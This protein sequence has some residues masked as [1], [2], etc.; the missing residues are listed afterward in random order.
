[1]IVT[2]RNTEHVCRTVESNSDWSAKVV[3]GD[4]DSLFVLLDGR[5]T[6]EAFRIGKEIAK[7]VTADN[8]AA[9]VLKLEKVLTLCVH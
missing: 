2:L 8:P 6:A 7:A 4:T 9:V 1:M 3:Y 5:S